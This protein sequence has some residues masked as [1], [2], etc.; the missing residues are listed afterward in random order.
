MTTLH[1]GAAIAR[2][3]LGRRADRHRPEDPWVLG[4]VAALGEPQEVT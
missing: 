3:T 4:S 2:D 1:E